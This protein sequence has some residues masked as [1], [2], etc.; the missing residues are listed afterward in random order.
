MT[1]QPSRTL[2]D[3]TPEEREQCWGMWCKLSDGSTGILAACDETYTGDHPRL[4]MIIGPSEDEQ[5]VL[6][7]QCEMQE[8]TPLFGTLRAW[9]QDGTLVTA[10]PEEYTVTSYSHLAGKTSLPPGTT[11]R[12][13]VS[14]WEEVE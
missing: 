8:I 5:A 10:D 7:T 2:A 9:K 14:D 11:V 12:R 6:V 4:A 3:M 1:T 13:W